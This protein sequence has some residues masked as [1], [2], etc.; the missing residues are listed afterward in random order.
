MLHIK[1]NIT[2]IN[3]EILFSQTS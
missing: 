2:Y 3:M 1:Q